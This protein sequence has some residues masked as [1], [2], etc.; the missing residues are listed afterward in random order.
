[1][2]ATGFAIFETAI[3]SCGIAWGAGGVAGVQ[4]P[5]GSAAAT[6]RRLAQRFPGAGVAPAPPEVADAIRRI[7]ALLRGERTD[8]TGI[9][10][11]TTALAP[12]RR[13]VY[14]AARAI[15]PGA[16][17]TYGQIA[18]RL[19]EPEA[20]REV[21]RAL[22][23][24]PFAI[25]VPCHRVLAAGGR[26]GGFSAP[27]GVATKLRLLAIE[28]GHAERQP[29]L[30]DGDGAFPF[31]PV[32]AVAELRAADSD[33]AKLIDTVGPFTMQLKRTTSVFGALA[34]SIVH[35]QLSTKA[36][37]T[38]YARMCALFPSVVQ[39]PTA[40][41]LLRASDEKLRSA[42]LSRAK[43]LALRDLAAKAR[44]NAIPTL[45]QAKALDDEAIVERLTAVRGIGRWSAEMF[46]MFR[47]GRPDILP[48]DD[49]GVRKGYAI[50]FRKRAL[51]EP[52]KLAVLGE[53]WRPWR[54]VAS[55]YLWQ[56]LELP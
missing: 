24:N 29:A 56:A 37:A 23:T 10:L 8:L 9:A 18:A 45:A 19:G 27:G 55:W 48:V 12:F 21:G 15:G 52:K 54:T 38:I 39:G 42:G 28:S 35:Q 13:R 34:E 16:T 32:R 2:A 33:L 40:E 30:F 17:L 36:A 50:A 44:A 1:M 43:I 22:A 7:T 20:A 26:S 41:H 25:V 3:G 46:L 51:P 4:L 6:R 11:D 47:L 14:E 53:R 31:D 5:D 49:Y